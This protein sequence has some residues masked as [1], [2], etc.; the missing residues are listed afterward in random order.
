[1]SRKFTRL[2]SFLAVI[3]TAPLG[4]QILYQENFGASLNTCNAAN[5]SS[6]NWVWTGAGGCAQ[7]NTGAHTIPGAATFSGSSCQ[8]G[9]GSNTVSGDLLTPSV[10][11]GPSGATLSFKYYIYNECS[12]SASCT[13]DQ[14]S[15][16]IST[17]NGA[18]YTNLASTATGALAGTKP[19]I[20]IP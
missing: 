9:N 14:L 17:N 16:W 13:Y 1:M 3:L 10:A 5:G 12:P 8:F 7:A 20:H 6:G 4:A 19:G 15:F 18:S 11:I 2:L